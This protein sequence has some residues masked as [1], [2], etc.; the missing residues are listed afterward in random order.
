MFFAGIYRDKDDVHKGL[1]N[2]LLPSKEKVQRNLDD[3][4][5]LALD[6]NTTDQEDVI[7][8]KIVIY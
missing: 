3:L 4:L 7:A 6:L 8:S 2:R 1:I 5:S